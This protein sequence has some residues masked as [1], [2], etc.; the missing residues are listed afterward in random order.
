MSRFPIPV[1]ETD[2]DLFPVP[3]GV[4]SVQFEGTIAVTIPWNL[5]IA[6]HRLQDVIIGM[7][8]E[9]WFLLLQR[10]Q[11]YVDAGWNLIT[12]S[13]HNQQLSLCQNILTFKNVSL[14]Q[15][16]VSFLSWN[17]V[18]FSLLNFMKCKVVFSPGLVFPGLIYRHYFLLHSSLMIQV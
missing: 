5:I 10:Y 13:T 18:H 8:V 7:T 9:G 14:I 1:R 11:I 17:L 2:N 15:S 16:G 6:V 3:K 12:N 4:Y